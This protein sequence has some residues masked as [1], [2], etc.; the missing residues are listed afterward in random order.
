MKHWAWA[1]GVNAEEAVADLLVA[2]D[3]AIVGR[4]VRIGGYE[5]D[6]VAI[7]DG[8]VAVVEV[9]T[10]GSG[11][12]Q[13]AFESISRKKRHRLRMGGRLLW[14]RDYEQNS[15]VKGLRY[16]AAAVYFEVGG[17]VRIEYVQGAF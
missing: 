16:D 6:I 13:G 17:G 10:R 14:D 3:Y 8:I 11:A 5:L 12:W 9:R 15:Q 2:H 4:N 7:R 1:K